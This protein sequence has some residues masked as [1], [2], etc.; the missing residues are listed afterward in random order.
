MAAI[1]NGNVT[2][3]HD[4]HG[5]LIDAAGNKYDASKYHAADGKI[6]EN[7][8]N[9]FVAWQDR[10]RLTNAARKEA[11]KTNPE[12]QKEKQAQAEKNEQRKAAFGNV[13][14]SAGQAAAAAAKPSPVSNP[15]AQHDARQAALAENQAAQLRAQQ[16]QANQIANRTST[17]TGAMNEAQKVAEQSALQKQRLASQQMVGDAGL[18]NAA[19]AKA[20]AEVDPSQ[21]FAGMQAL[22]SQ[23]RAR[24]VQ[25]GKDQTTYGSTAEKFRQATTQEIE[26]KQMRAKRD[27]QA[28]AASQAEAARQA[29]QDELNARLAESQ[30]ARNRA[31]GQK[32]SSEGQKLSSEGRKTSIENEAAETAAEQATDEQTIGSANKIIARL[33]PKTVLSEEE[34]LALYNGYIAAS[35]LKNG[36]GTNLLKTIAAKN[37]KD[38][39]FRDWFL[40][41]Y[42]ANNGKNNV[43]NDINDILS[44][45]CMKSIETPVGHALMNIW[46]GRTM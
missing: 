20:G 30:I 18:A 43:Y 38:A 14:Q 45:S 44:D 16:Q 11:D 12:V 7:G 21:H 35:K 9:R 13:L 6:I 25:L 19:A 26:D 31:E 39:T 29:S 8:T 32:L 22:G 46:K 33:T 15:Q 4:L 10:N 23:E 5:E 3:T 2:D 40:Q 17:T 1:I 27:A 28:E 42:E 36:S 34:K 41:T 37:G 24:A